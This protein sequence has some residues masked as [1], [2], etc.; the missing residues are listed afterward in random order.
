MQKLKKLNIK[1]KK[2]FKLQIKQK[3][4]LM[5]ITSRGKL[6]HTSRHSYCLFSATDFLLK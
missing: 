2:S 5:Q 3:Y 6:K 4:F 1:Y